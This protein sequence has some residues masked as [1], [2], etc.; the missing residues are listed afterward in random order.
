MISSRFRHCELRLESSRNA[1][2]TA[3]QAGERASAACGPRTRVGSRSSQSKS[4]ARGLGFSG[5]TESEPT[6]VGGPSPAGQKC[7]SC[8]QPSTVLGGT[9]QV[10]FPGSQRGDF[11]SDG[12]HQEYH[13]RLLR[14]G[15][16]RLWPWTSELL[17]E[18]VAFGLRMDVS[19]TSEG[20]ELGLSPQIPKLKWR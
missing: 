11:A 3:S 18:R 14:Q 15:S 7:L 4:F 8:V 17:L 20:Q 16:A 10:R 13:P 12:S 9:Q 2:G 19:C 6:K 1:L 5:E